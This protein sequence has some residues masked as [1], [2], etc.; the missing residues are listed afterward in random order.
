MNDSTN[1]KQSTMRRLRVSPSFVIV[2]TTFI[3]MIGFGMVI[4]VLPFHP[5]TV[6]AGALALG[7]LI[8]SFSLMQFIFSPILGRL[9]DKVGRRPVILISILS[10]VISFVLFA[11]A[12]SFLL[13]LLSRITAGIATEASVA[14]AYI[15]D[16]TTE[17]DRAKGMGKV[18]AAHGAG[19]IIGPAIGGFLSVYGLSTLGFA[20]AAL[21]GVNLLFAFFFLPESN[22]RV[23]YATKANSDGYWRRLGSAL[24]KPLIGAVFVILF[25]ITFAFSAVPVIVPLLGVAFFGF[26]ELEMSYFFMYVGVVQIVL[27]G[28]LI[29]RL[30]ARWGE[31]NLMVLGSLLMAL[32]MLCMPL[33][34]SIV[35]FFA[36][37]TLISSGIGTLNTVLPSFISKRT[38]ADEQG[39]MLGVAQSVGS[40]ARIPGPL[41]G[42]VVAEFAGLNVAFFVSAVL[43]MV[44]FFIGFKLFRA[45]RLN[46]KQTEVTGYPTIEM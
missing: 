46:G 24:T 40:I 31:E 3:D 37:I 17:K 44:C 6:G 16:I 15:S 26:T 2:M 23:G 19:F 8:G 9:S 39:G 14:Q 7:I 41:F 34:P 30:T 22:G 1:Q 43:V 33:Y 45:H 42:G 18:G 10:S 21:T 4:P 25:V 12:N 29:G 13:L 36:S 5:E 11:L 35:V 28:V 38:S 27:Q 20:A 32:G